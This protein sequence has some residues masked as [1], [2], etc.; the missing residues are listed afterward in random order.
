MLDGAPEFVIDAASSV[1]RDLFAKKNVYRRNG[2]REDVV[3]RGL[4]RALDWFEL[5]D[6]EDVKR[7]PDAAGYLESVQFP[8]LRLNVIRLLAGDFGKAVL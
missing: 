6:G 2:A 8:G 3:W 5:Q 7:E 1:S 4:D